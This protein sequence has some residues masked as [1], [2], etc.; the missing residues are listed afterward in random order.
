[1]LCSWGFASTF[2]G[3]STFGAH[4]EGDVTGAFIRRYFL[5]FCH[6][7]PFLCRKQLLLYV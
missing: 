4:V 2:S 5:Q 7:T 1:M 3:L 6:F